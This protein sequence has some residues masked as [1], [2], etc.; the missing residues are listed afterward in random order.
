MQFLESQDLYFRLLAFKR[1]NNTGILPQGNSQDPLPEMTE[2][3]VQL[4]RPVAAKERLRQ[5]LLGGKSSALDLALPS[6][7]TWGQLPNPHVCLDFLT[8]KP[9]Y[10]NLP[11]SIVVRIK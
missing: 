10:E 9:G 8:Y 2:I 1:R 5:K 3:Y 11:S 4:P 7:L 6:L